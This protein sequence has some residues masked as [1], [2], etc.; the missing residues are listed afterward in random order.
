M[1]KGQYF[2]RHRNLALE[3]AELE[4]KWRVFEEERQMFEAALQSRALVGVAP[5][6]AGGGGLSTPTGTGQASLFIY[7]RSEERRVR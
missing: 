2:D 4:R 7:Y 1:N 3:Q 5:T 6:S